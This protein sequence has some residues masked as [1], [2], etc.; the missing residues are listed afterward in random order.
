MIE[1]CGELKPGDPWNVHE[2][3][4]TEDKYPPWPDDWEE[5][6]IENF[7][8]VEKAINV[9]KKSGNYHFSLKNYI[10]SE[11][12]YVKCLRYIDWYLSHKK[13]HE[14]IEELRLVLIMNLAAVKLNRHK[15]KEVVSLCT[16]VRVRS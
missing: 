4:G 1:N 15:Y 7:K 11:R 9:I 5:E 2:N 10:D 6:N 8:A 16:Q 12:K 13:S 14:V 3:D